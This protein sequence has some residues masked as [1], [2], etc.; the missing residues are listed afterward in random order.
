MFPCMV[1]YLSL[2]S[3]FSSLSVFVLL[4]IIN[5]F[6]L[7]ES[8]GIE[9][10]GM[11]RSFSLISRLY[12]VALIPFHTTL[13]WTRKQM[14][15]SI[16]KWICYSAVALYSSPSFQ[17]SAW[18][19]LSAALV[20]SPWDFKAWFRQAERIGSDLNPFRKKQHEIRCL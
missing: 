8:L 18:E 9:F 1:G 5:S 10:M 14:N 19:S 17:E 12:C 20:P 7:A 11:D 13:W 6:A 2:K 3:C 16:N 4:F 15:K